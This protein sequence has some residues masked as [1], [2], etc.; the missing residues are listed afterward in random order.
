MALF[1]GPRNYATPPLLST[2]CTGWPSNALKTLRKANEKISA[3][4][5]R[6][7]SSS[8]GAGT[9]AVTLSRSAPTENTNGT[10]L[11]NLAGF[12]IY[13]GTS[14]AAMTNKISINTVGIQT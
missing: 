4:D 1:R 8:S 3:I 11:T 12:N 6:G 7:S 13:Y 9:A 2:L 5:N 10:A 14:T